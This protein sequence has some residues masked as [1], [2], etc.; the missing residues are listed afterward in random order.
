MENESNTT[1]SAQQ[2]LSWLMIGSDEEDLSVDDDISVQSSE[3][4]IPNLSN[5]EI[6][7]K[8]G[9]AGQGQVWHGIHLGTQ[10]HVA[11]K[12]PKFPG[13][14]SQ[15]LFKRFEREIG[16]MS[17]VEHPNIVQILDS[18]IHKG[19]YFYAMELVNGPHLDEYVRQNHLLLRDILRLFAE[20]CEA[21]EFMHE[22]GVIHRDLKPSNILVSEDGVPNILDFGLAKI[23]TEEAHYTTL[24]TDDSRAGTPAFMSPEQASGHSGEAGPASDIFSLG[25]IL[26]NL[27]TNEYPIDLSGTRDDVL[28]R[29]SQVKIK[30]TDS[31]KIDNE[32]K[33]IFKHIFQKDPKDRYKSARELY[34]DINNYLDNKPLIAGS[35]SILYKS[36]KFVK[37]HK[38]AVV[39]SGAA[40]C[41]TIAYAGIMTNYNKHNYIDKFNYAQ[42]TELA[43]AANWEQLFSTYPEPMPSIVFNN[44]VKELTPLDDDFVIVPSYTLHAVSPERTYQSKSEDVSVSIDISY[45]GYWSENAGVAFCIQDKDNFYYAELVTKT[46]S[47][48]C[49]YIKKTVNGKTTDLAFKNRLALDITHDFNLLVSYSQ[50]GELSVELTDKTSSQTAAAIYGI[51]DSSFNCG[52]AGIITLNAKHT[53]LDN[54]KVKTKNHQ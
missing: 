29:I 30:Y 33:K 44:Q 2:L 54:F 39:L 5:Y 36:C 41:A 7:E 3:D 23:E 11:I 52:R 19:I 51:K 49:L 46:E 28:G 48:D 22:K 26:Y 21:V 6:V 38:K 53:F 16:V 17:R 43:A 27:L 35:G 42:G 37:R 32:L 47:G 31:K 4:I 12:V 24:T 45:D 8:I 13:Y 9:D 1:L 50:S 40:A 10:K 25:I 20:I 15:Q 14:S 34:T 18:D